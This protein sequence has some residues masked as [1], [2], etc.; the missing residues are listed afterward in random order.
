MEAYTLK[1]DS[2]IHAGDEG[3]KMIQGRLGTWLPRSQG[4]QNECLGNLAD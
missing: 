4:Q 2:E 1:S 3:A